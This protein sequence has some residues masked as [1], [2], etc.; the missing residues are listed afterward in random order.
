MMINKLIPI[1]LE[2]GAFGDNGC[3]D[4]IKTDVDME[5][6]KESLLP[7]GFTY[8]KYFA[9][10]YIGEVVRLVLVKLHKA[11]LFIPNE[12]IKSLLTK[13]AFTAA[14]LSD[15]MLDS[16]KTREIIEAQLGI[17]G[18][19]KDDLAIIEHVCA[20]LS[21]RCCLLVSIPLA[22]FIDRMTSK[23][24]VAI[25]VT[26]SLYKHHPQVKTLMEK[27]ISKLCPGRQF[28][29]FLSDDGSGKGA[30]L[31]AAIAAR[32]SSS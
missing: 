13:D 17:K 3:I 10:K 4:F 9:G 21:E 26:G 1:C 29:T 16:S 6:D 25:A 5:L 8:E 23:E 32:L 20:I 24:H 12:E 15:V 2:F 18:T 7:G 30:G 27:Y 11:K 14:M 31:V 19:S 22:V 28:H